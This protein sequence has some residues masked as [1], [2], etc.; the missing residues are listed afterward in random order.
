MRKLPV[1]VALA[2]AVATATPAH[3]F[4][5]PTGQRCALVAV[6][7][8]LV[9]GG[10]ML[11]VLSGGPLTAAGTTM[12]LT[13][14]IQVG[15]SGLHTDPD[16]AWAAAGP[17]ATT[18]TLAPTPAS[19]VGSPNQP[20]YVCTQ[21]KQVDQNNVA[22]TLY[23]D[24]ASQSW[25]TTPGTAYCAIAP[26]P[27]APVEG[28]IAVIH[29]ASG[30][31]LAVPFGVLAD[32]LLWSC[33]IPT[34]SPLTPFVVSCTPQ[35]SVPWTCSIVAATAWVSARTGVVRASVDCNGDAVP[36]V[37]TPTVTSVNGGG[38]AVAAT[39][40]S[41]TSFDCRF[42]NGATAGPVAGYIAACMDPG[43]P[44]VR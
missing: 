13:C 15:G 36:E 44:E 18:V 37:Q 20:T 23:W 10:T 40:M 7:D 25:T 1:L 43:G 11:G 12:T 22:T 4:V 8:L 30:P 29:P 21:V 24:E 42:D 39:T 31:L 28:G 9:E 27:A 19:F 17:S 5:P 2:L 35:T 14:T 38:S 3:A 32:P 34:Y 26:A 16:A 6:Q 41:A 33:S